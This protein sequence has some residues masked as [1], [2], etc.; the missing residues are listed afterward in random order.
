MHGKEARATAHSATDTRS[1]SCS[2]EPR[3]TRPSTVKVLILYL[4]RLEVAAS[5]PHGRV[6]LSF[7]FAARGVWWPLEV[8]VFLISAFVPLDSRPFRCA[9]LSLLPGSCLLLCVHLSSLRPAY[10]LRSSAAPAPCCHIHLPTCTCHLHATRID[11]DAATYSLTQPHSQSLAHIRPTDRPV[12][13][14]QPT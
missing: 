10:P 8:R 4:P 2:P 3:R 5:R 1:A 13:T 12:A 11:C 6:L 7:F 9:C 14:V